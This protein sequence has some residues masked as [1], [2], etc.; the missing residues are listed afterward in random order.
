MGS[1]FEPGGRIMNR[2]SSVL[3]AAILGLAAGSSA[4][5]DTVR[6]FDLQKTSVNL[7]E[8]RALGT[9]LVEYAQGQASDSAEFNQTGPYKKIVRVAYQLAP[10]DTG[11]AA[12][13]ARIR[14]GQPPEAPARK[15]GR[16]KVMPGLLGLMANARAGQAKEDQSLVTYLAAVGTLIVVVSIFQLVR[17]FRL[18]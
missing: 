6:I 5:Q 12:A 1:D 8:A 10:E 16:D 4:A 11:V 15:L 13:H 3:A 9:L 2:R 17:A 18:I 7:E 14:A